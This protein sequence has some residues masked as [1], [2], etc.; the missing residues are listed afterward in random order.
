MLQKR[1]RRR[2]IVRGCETR[3]G[4]RGTDSESRAEGGE[5]TGEGPALV[6]NKD[7][8]CKCHPLNPR[9][10]ILSELLILLEPQ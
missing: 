9:P 10:G 8:N 6:L 5:L 3:L 1:D 7:R 4:E 2:K